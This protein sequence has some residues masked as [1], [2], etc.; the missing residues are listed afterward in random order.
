M[1]WTLAL[2]LAPLLVAAAPA[3]LAGQYALRGLREAAGGLELM[4]D[5]RFR[6]GMSY[7]ALDEQAEGSWR[8]D[9]NSVRLTTEPAPHQPEW[10]LLATE[11]GDPGR[12]ALLL[13]N[14]VGQP[15]ANIEVYV[16]LKDGSIEQSSTRSGWME[17][18]L[19]ARHMPVAVRFNIPV[20]GVSSPE[21]PIDL[22]RGHRL[23]FRLDPRD[24]GVRDFRDW[25]LEV[26]G[27]ILA[28]P[29]APDGVGFHR[30]KAGE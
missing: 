30:L 17:A 25:P 7:G 22:A 8:L 15:I 13:E 14:P 4:P 29:E 10:A 9:C 16:R 11:P 12:F 26:R 27:D 20:F 19:D 6:Y 1:H 23:R 18:P 3:E 24:L 21:F 5:G 2:A 28:L